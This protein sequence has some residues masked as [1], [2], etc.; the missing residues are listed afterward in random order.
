[1]TV[2]GHTAN[3]KGSDA[4]RRPRNNLEA[5][6]VSHQCLRRQQRVARR[7]QAD[8]E[9]VTRAMALFNT[10]SSQDA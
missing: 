3:A 9:L 8:D 4:L 7:S 1:V 5:L 2:S 6:K 10:C